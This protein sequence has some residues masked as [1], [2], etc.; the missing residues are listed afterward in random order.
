MEKTHEDMHKLQP[1]TRNSKI[2]IF[3]GNHIYKPDKVLIFYSQLLLMFVK[4][5]HVLTIIFRQMS[6]TNLT[7]HY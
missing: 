5:A 4:F 7:Y 1:F 6:L 3:G 2:Q